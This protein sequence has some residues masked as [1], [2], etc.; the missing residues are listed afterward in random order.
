MSDCPTEVSQRQLDE[1]F[2]ASR[3]PPAKA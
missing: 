3:P 1:L 2:I